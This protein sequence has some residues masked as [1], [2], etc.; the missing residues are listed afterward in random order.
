MHKGKSFTVLLVAASLVALCA[1]LPPMVLKQMDRLQLSQTATAPL[2]G[3]QIAPTTPATDTMAYY[4]ERLALHGNM[5]SIPVD[6]EVAVMTEEEVRSAAMEQMQAYES[7]GVL[8]PFEGGD[9]IVQP[10]FA[11]AVKDVNHTGVYWTVYANTD[12][13]PSSSLLVYL[14]DATGKVLS[15]DFESIDGLYEDC[16]LDERRK[17][18][19]DLA[20]TF[21]NQFAPEGRTLA[22]RIHEIKEVDISK[23]GTSY[24]YILS[25]LEENQ[26]EYIV[27]H[28]TLYS[29]GFRIAC[30]TY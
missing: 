7:L 12:A 22:S 15:I 8:H 24:Q 18:I 21:L 28:V 25:G 23:N 6:T 17:L 19:E 4:L 9:T 5:Y 29:H 14:D 20:A 30:S 2:E 27:V 11:I 10:L 3:V 1:L 26:T 16:T 13:H